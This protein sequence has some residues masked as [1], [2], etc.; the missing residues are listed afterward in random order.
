MV[1]PTSL[2]IGDA[3]TIEDIEPPQWAAEQMALFSG[4]GERTALWID[5][6]N[7]QESSRQRRA[8]CSLIGTLAAYAARGVSQV[9][10]L[11][12]RYAPQQMA[13]R[14]LAATAHALE[15]RRR[16]RGWPTERDVYT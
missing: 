13:M 6:V 14:R 11:T 15:H 8:A 2:E 5:E 7:V 9:H 3:T 12:R 4:A 16:A 10:M 1:W